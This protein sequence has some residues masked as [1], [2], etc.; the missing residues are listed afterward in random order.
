MLKKI[1]E[2]GWQVLYFTC[3]DE[4]VDCLKEDISIG[5]VNYIE[6]ESFK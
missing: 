3:K 5:K 2:L 1:C 6:L 4:I